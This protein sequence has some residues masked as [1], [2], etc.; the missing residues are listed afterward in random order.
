MSF[1]DLIGCDE[2]VHWKEVD[3]VPSHPCLQETRVITFASI[4]YS[5]AAEESERGLLE[6]DRHTQETR[7]SELVRGG[8]AAGDDGEKRSLSLSLPHSL[9]AAMESSSRAPGVKGESGERKATL[10]EASRFPG[11]SGE[12]VVDP[13]PLSLVPF[14][15]RGVRLFL[16][17]CFLSIR[18]R[19]QARSTKQSQK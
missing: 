1:V 14:S 4:L 15:F 5:D 3:L 13:T 9:S 16:Y 6:P 17:S 10:R 12:E 19:K 11:H 18:R 8:P 7:R 2:A